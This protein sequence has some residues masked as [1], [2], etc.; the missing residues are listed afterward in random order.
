[1]ADKEEEEELDNLSSLLREEEIAVD[2]VE[3]PTRRN[4][5][6]TITIKKRYLKKKDQKPREE[7][8]QTQAYFN[9]S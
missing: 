1:M 9:V 2:S 6:T 8:T 7:T 3:T 4:V 5:P